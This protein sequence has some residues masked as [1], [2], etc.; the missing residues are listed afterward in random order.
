MRRVSQIAKEKRG[1]GC[2]IR[3]PFAFSAQK[4]IIIVVIVGEVILRPAAA[5]EGRA[6]GEL[7]QVVQ[8]AGDAAVAVDVVGIEADGRPADDA[9][10]P[11]WSA[12]RRVRLLLKG[13]G[14]L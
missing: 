5:A 8:P 9:A 13:S 2:L 3:H 10:V 11:S 12:F 14:N 1:G 6:V 4:I 7:L